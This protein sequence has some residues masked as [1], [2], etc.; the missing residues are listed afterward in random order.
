MKFYVLDLLDKQAHALAQS[1][2]NPPALSSLRT[3]NGWLAGI[4][5]SSRFRGTPSL[6][7]RL[8]RVRR[9]R[10]SFQTTSSLKRYHSWSSSRTLLKHRTAFPCIPLHIHRTRISHRSR[11]RLRRSRPAASCSGDSSGHLIIFRFLR[12]PAREGR[13]GWRMRARAGGPNTPQVGF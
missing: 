12:M 2:E 10:L 13:L 5:M 9:I 11:S 3:A 4:G 1:K 8:T 6:Q 7:M